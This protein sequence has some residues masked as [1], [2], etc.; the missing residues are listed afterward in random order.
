V[1]QRLCVWIRADFSRALCVR[2]SHLW[3]KIRWK[4]GATAF[5]AQFFPRIVNV[6]LKIDIKIEVHV[7]A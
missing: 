4:E 1:L 5:G 3:R 6:C 7:L 2:M